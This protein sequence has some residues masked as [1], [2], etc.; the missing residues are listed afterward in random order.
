[1]PA[2]A[3]SLCDKAAVF[4]DTAYFAIRTCLCQCTAHGAIL[5]QLLRASRCNYG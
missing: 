4:R 5:K 2:D 1:M 3:G